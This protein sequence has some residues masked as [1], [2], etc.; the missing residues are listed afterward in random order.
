VVMAVLV[1]FFPVTASFSD[2]LRRTDQGWL[3]LARTMNASPLSVLW[4][5]RLPAALPAFGSG[6]RVAT[7]IAPIGAVIG[8]W[9][10]ASAGLGFVMLNANARIE[11]DLMFAALFVLSL[12]TIL[13]WVVVDRVL[14]KLLFW[15]PDTTIPV[16]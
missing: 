6:L 12:M 11:T 13:L 10:G 2:G 8:E 9:V 4:H 7:A 16:G 5:V 15:A 14:R 3:D 1:I